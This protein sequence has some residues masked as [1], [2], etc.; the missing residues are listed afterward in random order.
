MNGDSRMPRWIFIF[1]IPMAKLPFY[2][3]LYCYNFSKGPFLLE[4][5]IREK[6]SNSTQNLFE[7]FWQGLLLDFSRLLHLR[8]SWFVFW[9]VVTVLPTVSCWNNK[10]LLILF[11]LEITIPL[12]DLVE[13]DQQV[14]K[15]TVPRKKYDLIKPIFFRNQAKAVLKEDKKIQCS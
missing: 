12:S 3:F 8:R 15:I 4:G 11:S 14:K 2:H 7:I 6:K 10:I 9:H 13:F 5:R 1:K